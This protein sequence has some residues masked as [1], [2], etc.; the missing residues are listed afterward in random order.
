MTQI[1]PG[2]IKRIAIIGAGP[3]GLAA[4]K[5]LL[6]EN[7]FSEI[8]IY[9]QRNSVG[10]TWNYTP[11]PP[12][13]QSSVNGDLNGSSEPNALDVVT[14]NLPKLNTPMYEG[15]E[16]NLPHML[17]QFSDTPFPERTQL[18]ARR[19]TVQQYL[20]DYASDIISMIRFGHEV[21]EVRPTG[22]DECHGWEITTK[23]TAER[24]SK[25]ERFDAVVAANGHCD[26]PLL[27]KVEGLDAWCK[28][29]PDSLYHSVSFK[30][31]KAFEKKRVLL[32]GGGP[33][34][35]D[36]GR[37]IAR[38]CEHPFLS[39]Q[40][41]KSPYHTDEPDTRDYSTLVALMPDERAAKF[42]DGSVERN[43][44]AIIL[45]T[46]YAY[47]FPFLA[48]VDPTIKDEGIRALPLYQYI[49]H[50]QHPTLAFIETP[51]MIV[52]FPLAECQAAVIARVWS[53][54]LTLPNRHKMQDWRESVVRERGAAREFHALK[55]P[56][57]LEYMKEM[58]DWSSKATETAACEG[59][60]GGKMPKWWDARAC[61]VRMMAAEM[62]KA[63]NARGE[64][65][66]NVLTYEELGFRFDG[67]GNEP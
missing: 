54:R 9:E 60:A 52:P 1:T 15:L 4:A 13:R 42:A 63:F 48:P 3:S 65:R 33:S 16:S 28:Q 49:F 19:D 51:E 2:A 17:M 46:G 21:H 57:D 10:G 56:L 27:P 26:W 58:Y 53:S 43:I 36:I 24:E 18:F 35:A 64:A 40:P 31:P 59:G 34:G 38:V 22:G 29:F 61:W 47:S 67:E 8:I 6:A 25:V 44:D 7:A 39:A 32:V 12:K 20:Q 5:Y 23:A 55:P 45:C 66:S 37:Q 14:A 50:I 30:N 41:K 62:K 11:L